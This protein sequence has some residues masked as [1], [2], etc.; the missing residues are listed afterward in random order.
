MK[1]RP[2]RLCLEDL[3]DRVN[4]EGGWR[5]RYQRLSKDHMRGL[6]ANAAPQVQEISR[7]YRD[8]EQQPLR[9]PAGRC[10]KPRPR[11]P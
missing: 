4:G 1:S 11:Q 7:T 3:P 6:L 9:Q 5:T 10:K 2:G 8:T